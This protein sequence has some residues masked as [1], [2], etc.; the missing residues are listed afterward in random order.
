MKTI[1]LT[2]NTQLGS[3]S[4]IVKDLKKMDRLIKPFHYHHLGIV[5]PVRESA[6][7]QWKGRLADTYTKH[8]LAPEGEWEHPLWKSNSLYVALFGCARDA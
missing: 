1:V 4:D 7:F 8:G 5:F 6:L 2:Q 3:I